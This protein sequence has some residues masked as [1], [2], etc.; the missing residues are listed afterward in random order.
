MLG[1]V[2]Q[3][4]VS[5]VMFFCCNVWNL[6]SLQCVSSSNQKCGARQK[7]ININSNEPLF[8]PY[9]TIINKCSGS[10][11]DINYAYAKLCVPNVV[12][13]INVKVFTLM[14]KTNETRHTGKYGACRCKCRLNASVC[15]NKNIRIIK[16]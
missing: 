3:I 8:Y 15:N 5:V 6:N 4:F 13:S 10:F 1:F 14:S 9:S 12:K 11:N 2:K 16:M 7:I